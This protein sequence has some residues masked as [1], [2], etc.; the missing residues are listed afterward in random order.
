MGEKTKQKKTA[1]EFLGSGFQTTP[2]PSLFK[3]SVPL[4]VHMLASGLAK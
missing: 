3:K 4:R 1:G 2:Q